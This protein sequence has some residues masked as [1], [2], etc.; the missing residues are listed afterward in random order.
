MA[1]PFVS[2]IVPVYN[3][4]GFLDEALE[5]VVAQGY[6]PLEII[7]VDDGSEDGSGD[8]ARTHPVRYMRQEHS[9]IATARNAGVEAAGGELICFLDADDAWAA[10]KL[11][12][13]VDHLLGNPEIDLVLG[14]MEIMVEPGVDLPAWFPR[15]W[16]DAPQNG[17]LPTMVAR[18]SVFDRVGLFDPSYSVGEDTEW[19][20]RVFNAGIRH[21]ALPDVVLRYRMHGANTTHRLRPAARPALMRLLRA[22][23]QRS[24]EDG[25]GVEHRVG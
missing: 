4:A 15:A 24:R 19:L 3:A 5:S 7:V 25:E 10:G 17:L 6:E 12:A 1:D 9:G 14:R 2:A 23:A 16:L 22:A 11:R 20:A 8:V 13:Q 21:S 18:R